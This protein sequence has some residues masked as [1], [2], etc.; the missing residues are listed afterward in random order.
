MKHKYPLGHLVMNSPEFLAFCER[1][2]IDT[3]L[4]TIGYT[5]HIDVNDIMRVE[6]K[7]L[8]EDTKPTNG[9]ANA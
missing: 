4:R 7:Y 2:G 9:G 8:A 1:F 6:H 5:I 3:R